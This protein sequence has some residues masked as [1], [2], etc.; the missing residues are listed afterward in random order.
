MPSEEP[1]GSVLPCVDTSLSPTTTRRSPPLPLL[2]TA[3]STLVAEPDLSNTQEPQVLSNSTQQWLSMGLLVL[4]PLAGWSFRR[5][6]V[7][8]P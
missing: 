4:T 5:L 3:C 1:P 6:P 2:T 7:L 8:T